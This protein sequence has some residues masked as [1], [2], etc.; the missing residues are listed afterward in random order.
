MADSPRVP[1]ARRL[2][3][4]GLLAVDA[5]VA[6]AYTVLAVNLLA[7]QGGR[8]PP[9]IGAVLIAVPLAI[10]RQRPMTAYAVLLL[11]MS[12][13]PGTPA[14]GLLVL[15]PL[16]LVLAEIAAFRTARVALPA[17]ALGVGA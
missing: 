15:G 9:V 10:H 12:W 4:R 13:A 6:A 2:G 17:L 1:L 11:A 14:L 16:A 8:L 3:T 5:A 7:D